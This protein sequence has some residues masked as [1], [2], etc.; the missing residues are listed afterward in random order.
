MAVSQ[1]NRQAATPVT[2]PPTLLRFDPESYAWRSFGNRTLKPDAFVQ[3]GIDE[4]GRRLKG[5]SSSR[6][7]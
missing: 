1:P 4:A 7:T 2:L 6:L 3:I 5:A